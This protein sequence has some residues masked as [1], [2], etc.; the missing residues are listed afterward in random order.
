MRI[1]STFRCLVLTPLVIAVAAVVASGSASFAADSETRATKKWCWWDGTAPFCDGGCKSGQLFEGAWR[2]EDEARNNLEAVVP[3]VQ[4]SEF[5][6]SFGEDCVTGTKALCCLE[7]CPNGYTLVK[8]ECKNVSTKTRD[9]TLPVPEGPVQLKKKG[10]IVEAPGPVEETKLKKGPIAAPPSPV[11][12]TE[13]EKGPIISNP[14]ES[15]PP[16]DQ[17]E[18][19]YVT[20]RRSGPLTQ[21]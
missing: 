10:P 3:G 9:L 5:W 4:D 14:D 20:K 6:R 21:D 17:P 11:E 7:V 18:Q 16:P 8:G 1:L 19:P 13:I 12:E 15:A 2:N